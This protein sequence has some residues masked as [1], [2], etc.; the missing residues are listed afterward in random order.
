[1]T[2]EMLTHLLSL[3]QEYTTPCFGK[4]VFLRI[5]EKLFFSLEHRDISCIMALG[6]VIVSDAHTVFTDPLHNATTDLAIDASRVF[7]PCAYH[8]LG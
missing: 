3:W 1:M 8:T 7:L 5:Y 2:L 6:S 4:L